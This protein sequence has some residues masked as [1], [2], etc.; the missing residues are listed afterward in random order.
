MAEVEDVTAGRVGYDEQ[1]TVRTVEMPDEAALYG[2][3]DVRAVRESLHVSQAL[4]AR[5][6]GASPALVRAWEMGSR[7]PSPM[8]R[9]LLDTIRRDPAPWRNMV[10]RAG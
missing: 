10:R 6:V 5:M 1:F 2:P 8:A 7:V 9:R 4:F 3:S